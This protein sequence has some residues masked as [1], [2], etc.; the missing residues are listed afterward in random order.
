MKRAKTARKAG[1]STRDEAEISRFE[2]LAQ[3]WWDPSGPMAPLHKLNPV[4]L[5]Y[6]KRQ[7]MGH[8]DAPKI[9]KK[10]SIL[11]IGCGAGLVTEPLS[12]HFNVTGVDA[13]EELIEAAKAHAKETGASATYRV[14]EIETL[15]KEKERF[16]VVLALE[17]IEHVAEPELFAKQCMQLVKPDG[18]IIFSTLNRTPKAFALGVVAAEVILRWLPLGTHDWRKFVKPSE[19]AGWVEKE[20]ALVRDITG[21]VYSPVSDRFSLNTRDV[22]VNYFM[23]VCRV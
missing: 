22:D 12:A 4:R 11:D 20:H 18:L 9:S 21:L 23:T 2:G 15:A 13:G 10:L 17:V 7:I 14:A 5:D 3:Q 6:I 16:D 8:F 19:L 1:P